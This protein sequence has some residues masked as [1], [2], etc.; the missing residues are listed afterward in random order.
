MGLNRCNLVMVFW[1]I[2]H[3][4]IVKEMTYFHLSH[5]SI[6]YPYLL[7]TVKN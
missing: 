2:Y 3:L 7:I 1:L 4:I 5:L 6:L